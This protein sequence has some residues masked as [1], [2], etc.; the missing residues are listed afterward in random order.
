MINDIYDYLESGFKIFG[1]HGKANGVCGCGDVDCT[2][3]YKHPIMSNWQNVPNWSDDQIEC[4]DALGHFNTGFGVLCKGWLI[5]DVDAR[6]GGVL[7]FKQLCKDVPSILTCGYVVNTGSGGGSQHWYFKLS[8][9]DKTKSLMQKHDKYAGIDFKTSGY[10]VG[11]GSLHESGS[12]YETVKGYPQDTGFAPP[13][14]IAL[15][16]RPA[17]YRV[18]NNGQDLD[19]DEQH[20]EGLLAF[21]DADCDYN[22]WVSVGMAIHHCLSGGGVGLW[23]DWSSKGAKYCGSDKINRHWH[24]FG[25]TSNPVGY[26][27][28][29]HYANE[30]GYCEPVTFVY[31]GSLGAVDD[32]P[33]INL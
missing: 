18:S 2:A 17:F 23:D 15:L 24:S 32:A 20:I 8:D 16:E 21:I 3:F 13:E 6:N 30:G 4:F 11:A 5:I 28:L 22:Q 27:T 25:K 31:D 7:S 1:L 14:L 33:S 10:V 12:N 19:I 26:G 29:L 9:D